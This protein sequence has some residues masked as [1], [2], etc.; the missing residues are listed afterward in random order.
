MSQ[1][2]WWRREYGGG[3]GSIGE[4]SV[5]GEG[6]EASIF[7]PAESQGC[8]DLS[9]S[10]SNLRLSLLFTHFLATLGDRM[11]HGG[12]VSPLN[13]ILE[14]KFSTQSASVMMTKYKWWTV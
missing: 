7:Q 13:D 12:I 14:I 9:K 4:G 2:V 10:R 6:K 8:G 3:A 1:E 5:R 11:G